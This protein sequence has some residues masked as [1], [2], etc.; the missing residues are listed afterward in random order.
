M[1]VTYHRLRSRSNPRLLSLVIP[2]YNEQQVIPLLRERLTA[3][4]PTLPCET[5]V[6]IVNDGSSDRTLDLLFDW[7]DADPRI[8]VLG[9]A[10]NFGHQAAVTAGLDMASGDA[11]VIMDADLQDPL[12]VLVEMLG[13]YRTGYDV[14]Y[15]QRIGREGETRFKK[16]TAWLFYRLMR[17]LV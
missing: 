4:L 9:L 11:I 3:F 5:E 2:A 1:S 12:E 17:W 14:V 8:K 15:G 13:Q 7:A 10:R 16:L 6:I